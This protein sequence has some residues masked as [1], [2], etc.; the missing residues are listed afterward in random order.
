MRTKI[1][2]LLLA[3]ACAAQAGTLNDQYR[4]SGDAAGVGVVQAFDDGLNLYVQMRD[5]TRPP[6]PIGPV[7]AVD[8]R[9]R[10]MYLVLPLMR[11]V[12]LVRDG[13]EARIEA[14]GVA[15]GVAAVAAP[16]DVPS[17]LLTNPRSDF[18]PPP[19]SPQPRRVEGDVIVQGD[20][21]VAVPANP[22]A[23][24]KATTRQEVPLDV[25]KSLDL[26]H[27]RG[28]VTVTADGTAKGAAAA[29]AVRARCPKGVTCTIRYAG[30]P[31]GKLI[32]EETTDA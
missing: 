2:A 7:G 31:A 6:A 29:Q 26:A 21:P 19:P 22:A 27:L 30:A 10:G 5:P 25:A 32:I 24:A 14:E 16:V 13:Y 3:V 1:A 18:L 23:P 28:R 20:R 4:L 11:T 8:Y 9:I 17:P 12:R 15:A